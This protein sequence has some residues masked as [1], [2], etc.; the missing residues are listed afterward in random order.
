ME[1]IFVIRLRKNDHLVLSCGFPL[2]GLED[3]VDT[4]TMV[5]KNGSDRSDDTGLI[6]HGHADIVAALAFP[7]RGNPV[8]RPSVIRHAKLAILPKRAQH[9]RPNGCCRRSGACAAPDK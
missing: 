2:K 4:D 3:L 7:R 9:I 8:C 1:M 5:T 6:S